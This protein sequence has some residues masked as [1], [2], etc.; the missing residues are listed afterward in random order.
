MFE[1]VGVHRVGSMIR[2]KYSFFVGLVEVKMRLTKIK[3]GSAVFFGAFALVMYLFLGALQ[4][5]LR[6]VLLAQGIQLTA[7]QT[8]VYAPIIGGI[9]A[10]ILILIMIV[11]YNAVAKKYPIAWEIGKK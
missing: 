9:V 5:S 8:F 11:I 2:F 1:F 4:W 6:D 10:Y 7:L 3:Y